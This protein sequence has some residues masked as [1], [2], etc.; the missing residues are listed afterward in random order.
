M[1]CA[2]AP[3]YTLQDGLFRSSEE[4]SQSLSFSTLYFCSW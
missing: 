1:F 4:L 2:E 3:D